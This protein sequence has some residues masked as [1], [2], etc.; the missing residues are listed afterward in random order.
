MGLVVFWA[1]HTERLTNRLIGASAG[2]AVGWI[3]ALATGRVAP[4]DRYKRFYREFLGGEGPFPI[5]VELTH[6]FLIFRQ[7]M[8]N[9]EYHWRF[10]DEIRDLPDLIE[11][12]VRG[13]G[14]SVV[15]KGGF[16][17]TDEAAKFLEASQT[18]Q[19]AARTC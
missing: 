6:A 2:F 7:P 13:Y 8:V 9:I 17:T 11:Y 18:L 14:V 19:A 10:V 12:Y 16:L 3:I 15:R 4:R 5:E 1:L